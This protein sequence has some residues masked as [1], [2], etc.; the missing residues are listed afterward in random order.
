[1]VGRRETP[2]DPAAGPV[3]RFAAALRELRREAG[4]LTYR[5]M[6]A[7]AGYS[8]TTLSQAAAGERLP[9][10]PVVLA[11]VRACGGD[12]AEWERRW[13][14]AAEAAARERAA[15]EEPAAGPYL[16][17]AAYG[18]GDAGRFFGRD[19]LVEELRE[20]LERHR[21]AAV[22]GPSGSGK[23][24]LLRAGLAAGAGPCL[25]LTPGEHPMRHAGRLAP[26]EDGT[27]VVVD[28]FEEVFTLCR[29][30][31]ERGRFVDLLLAARGGRPV[32]IAVRADFYGRCAEHRELTAALREANV[33]VGPM[34]PE[35]LRE[36]IVRPAMAEGLT[37]ERALTAAVVADVAEEPGALPL[38]S[39]ALRE[40]WR[41]RTGKLL[42]LDAYRSVGRLHGAISHTAEEVYAAMSPAQARIARRVLLRLINPGEQAQDTRRP[43]A[44]AEL[45]PY[46]DPDVA[47]VIERLAGARLL[48]L[49]ED[50]VQLAHEAL[51]ESW[52]RLRGWVDEGRERLR[53][54]RRLTEAAQAWQA[55]GRDA[56]LLYRGVRLAEATRLFPEP[57][58]R[59]DGQDVLT[60]LERG[61][62]EASAAL[63]RRASRRRV[64]VAAALVVLLA[65]S[66]AAAG[67]AVRQAGLADD[68]L[69]EATAR[70][71]ARRAAALRLSDPRLARR[72]SAAA[73][74]IAPVAEARSELIDSLALPLVDVFTVPYPPTDLVSA[75]SVDGARLAV[76]TPGGPGEPA[77]LR[78]L[79]LATRK[80]TAA[81][82]WRGREVH[83][84]VWSPDGRT[85]AVYDEGDTRFWAVRGGRLTDLGVRIPRLTPSEFSPDGRRLIGIRDESSEVWNV[86]DGT[87]ALGEPVAAISPDGR[88]AVVIPPRDEL[89][90]TSS[91]GGTGPAGQVEL[92]D[93]DRR[94]RLPAPWLD[95]S[96]TDAVF[97]PDGRRLALAAD[98][99]VR[100]FHLPSGKEVLPPLPPAAGHLEFSPDSRFLV[101]TQAEGRVT[102]WRADDGAELTRSPLPQATTA[103]D[104]RITP[105]GRLLRVLGQYG[106]VITLDVSPATRPAVLAPGTDQRLLS[107]DGRLLVT[108]GRRDGRSEVRVWDVAARRPVSGPLPL[109]GHPD[110]G[111]GETGYVPA[112]SPDGRILALSHPLSPTVTL[113][114]ATTGRGLGTFRAHDPDA[115]GIMSLTFSPDGGTVVFATTS[116]HLGD[117]LSDFDLEVWDVRAR[118]WLRT[119]PGAGSGIPIFEPDGRRLLVDSSAQ[120]RLAIDTATGQVLRRPYDVRSEGE[121]L[122][123]E[124]RAA[125]GDPDG[126]LTFWDRELRRPLTP[127]QNA[128]LG[129][130]NALVP[131][132]PGRL[133][134]TVAG[135]GESGV[136]LWD[137][138]GNQP[139]ATPIDFTGDSVPAVAFTR[140]TLLVST[141]DGMLREIVV[142]PDT[143]VAAICRRDGA[144]S[145]AEWR[146]QIPEL[147]Y[148]D[149]C[150]APPSR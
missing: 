80:E 17:L 92:W 129:P 81:T 10:L 43:A 93:L 131:Y 66:V 54:H 69:Q 111:S 91:G 39:H 24:S 14:E 42:T 140:T 90:A 121:I 77:V 97:S 137:W 106:T 32:V 20:L 44:R 64:A 74:R 84:L 144:L 79:D 60:P 119:V 73:W 87:R 109:D 98:H 147:P 142:D 94:A 19:R 36:A 130:I 123:V 122:F 41:R 83:G 76:F 34:R 117:G 12:A 68:R 53:V 58:E 13:H 56:G 150:R 30:P 107:P 82:T 5:A 127:P 67:V 85:L 9:S 115:I 3:Q 126:I 31:A 113:W 40:V 52:P 124:D 21:F 1:M 146:E 114:D 72:L 62:V 33:L 88:L 102:L 136:R 134:A 139:V 103:P 7:R 25:L 35:E 112:F 48:T 86:A 70:L 16:G 57:D 49:H 63:A 2:L 15:E 51:I 138:R 37:V 23:S 149:A 116:S 75:L 105:D 4:G 55:H 59:P 26:G 145:P 65:A 96:A 11:F 125:V 108:A 18:T 104:A 100:V 101:G 133:L 95:G 8:V 71:A 47:L 132:P 29:D 141:A 120:G 28:Q 61:F 89:R 45:D 46:G 148:Q 6:A 38:M 128:H 27:L 78:V 50:G 118:S 22:F 143:A 110:Q 135:A 99:E